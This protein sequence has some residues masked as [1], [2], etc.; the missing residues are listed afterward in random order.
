MLRLVLLMTLLTSL[1]YL[2]GYRYPTRARIATIGSLR[3]VGLRF[4]DEHNDITRFSA[5]GA[6]ATP[7]PQTQ[8]R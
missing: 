6:V 1:A 5:T 3:Q 4:R 7:K 8:E 2:L